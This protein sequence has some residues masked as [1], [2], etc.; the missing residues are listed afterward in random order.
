MRYK[1]IVDSVEVIDETSN[2]D[3]PYDSCNV[4]PDEKFIDE[5]RDAG[6]SSNEIYRMDIDGESGILVKYNL[7]PHEKL[8]WDNENKVMRL[9]MVYTP[10]I[11]YRKA[12]KDLDVI[13]DEK[14]W[15]EQGWKK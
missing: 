5:L 14:Y 11:E 13:Y 2:A 3:D 9:K 12:L 1:K 7:F 4:R 15:D 8:K 6:F 10:L